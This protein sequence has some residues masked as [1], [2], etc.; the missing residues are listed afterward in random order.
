MSTEPIQDPLVGKHGTGAARTTS[1]RPQ[2]AIRRPGD[3]PAPEQAV[4]TRP[5]RR[6]GPPGPPRRGSR[7]RPLS[8]A[9]VLIVGVIAFGL[10]AL[11]NSQSLLDMANRQPFDSA[12]RGLALA[13]T[14]PMHAVADAFQLTRPGEAIADYRGR[15][16]GRD[17]FA[18]D[19]PT[20]TVASAPAGNDTDTGAATS[21]TPAGAAA[22]TTTPP[23]TAAHVPTK[24][25]KL[26]LY[27][28]GDSQA[29]G[30]G[31][32]LE[33]LAGATGLVA[34]TLDFKVSS[35]LTRPDFFDW[36]KRLQDQV[37]KV[38]PDIVVIDFGGNDAQPIKASDG[39]TYDP[40]DPKWLEEYSRRVGQ[41]MDF[42]MQDGRKVIW[43]GTPN[44][45]DDGFTARLAVLRQAEQQEAAKRPQVSFVDVWSMFQ[46]PSGGYADYIVDDDGQAK[47][48]RQNDG[49]HLNLDG[50]N[51]L[52]RAIEAQIETEIKARGG[53]LG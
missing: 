28:A 21:V 42:L 5:P 44:A 34:P 43:V 10:A 33:R 31:E 24:E 51:K 3:R 46:S 16:A 50:A 4:D 26:R 25:D 20:T 49:F 17:T 13:V 27:I 9:Q 7:D 47:L 35:G 19:A 41:T 38:R 22:A 36:P 12:T 29:Q 11:L 2:A 6:T 37:R 39:N 52:A 23:S 45:K 48:M 14:K 15:E 8:A 30:F 53:K 1:G 18:F 40:T 32:S